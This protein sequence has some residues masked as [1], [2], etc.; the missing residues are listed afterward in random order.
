M[1]NKPFFDTIQGNML[2][3]NADTSQV[4]VT[5]TD[6]NLVSTCQGNCEFITNSN[7]TETLDSFSVVGTTLHLVFASGT[8]LSNKVFNV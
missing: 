5:V 7:I 6:N 1:Q 8:D 4:L 3:R 2:F